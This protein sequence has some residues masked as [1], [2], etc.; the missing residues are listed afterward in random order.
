MC[1]YELTNGEL[2]F[3]GEFH[4]TFFIWSHILMNVHHVLLL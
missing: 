2:N 1:Y 3:F 4:P